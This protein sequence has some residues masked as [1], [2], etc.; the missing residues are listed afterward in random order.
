[1][2]IIGDRCTDDTESYIKK[3]N[4]PRVTFENLNYK[5]KPFKETKENLWLA[6]EVIAANYGLSL[7]NGAWIARLDDD[8]VFTPTHIEKLLNYANDE[9]IEFVSG[10]S[11]SNINNKKIIHSGPFLQSE[12]FRNQNIKINNK[13]VQLGAHS[14]WL[15]K[16]YLKVFKY[17]INCWRKKWNRVNDIDLAQRFFKSGVKMGFLEESVLIQDPRPGENNVGFKAL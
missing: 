3:L 1:M 13:N 16:N 2:I 11:H 4:D 14:T 15:Y 7:S 10:M 6:G 9:N 12:Y 5:K 8:D 17:N